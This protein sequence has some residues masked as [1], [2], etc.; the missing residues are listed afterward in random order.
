MERKT[1][2]FAFAPI[3]IIEGEQRSGKSE[4][5][6]T[7]VVD[8]TYENMTHIKLKDGTIIKADPVLN[9][10]GYPMIG[11]AKINGKRMKVPNGSCVIAEDI[12][13]FANF[14]LKGIR[15]VF[16]PLSSIIEH[17][18]DGSLKDCYLI[19][20][21]AYIAGDRRE[22][23]SPLV[24]TISKLGWQIGKRHIHFI[25]CLPD[26]SVLDLRLQK[27]ETEH[28]VCSYDEFTRKITMF[29]KNRKRY[30]KTR[31]VSYYAPLYWKYYDT[32]ENFELP[33]IQL[34]RALASVT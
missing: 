18:N 15:Y 22:G 7:R 11:F 23:L 10:E 32:D 26:S 3:T 28:I 27:I 29:I 8:V 5:A 30:K 20:D 34:A 21:E 14:H 25:M 1:T 17:L 19:I 13:I 9:D 31:E 12:K 2:P 33:N 24:K 6:V 16:M 4:T